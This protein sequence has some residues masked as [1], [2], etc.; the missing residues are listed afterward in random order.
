MG[1]C[2]GYIDRSSSNPQT[3]HLTGKV[4]EERVYARVWAHVHVSGCT[5]SGVCLE[6]SAERPLAGSL[7]LSGSGFVLP[8][9][10]G[11]GRPKCTDGHLAG[12]LGHGPVLTLSLSSP[13][14][15]LLQRLCG[16]C[17][18]VVGP[19][20]GGAVGLWAGGSSTGPERGRT[21]HSTLDQTRVEE[22]LCP[23][24]VVLMSMR[25]EGHRVGEPWC[26]S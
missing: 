14:P 17:K 6:E 21:A 3:R 25:Q 8:A 15:S 11:L 2:L 5:R 23:C 24:A 1:C 9:P 22:N 26:C 18:G 19:G 10:A 7:P 13:H 12:T 16:L 20:Q 4:T